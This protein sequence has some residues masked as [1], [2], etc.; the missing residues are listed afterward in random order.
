MFET[1]IL[2]KFLPPNFDHLESLIAPN[3][4][5]STLDN[6]STIQLANKRYKIIQEAKRL[7]LDVFLNVYEIQI[8]EYER[9]YENEFV[10]FQS[11]LLFT[12]TTIN[13]TCVI[14]D[15]CEYITY[16][17][18]KFKQDIYRQI[19]SYRRTLVQ[20]RQHSKLAK[21]TVGVSPE[22]YLD[23]LSNPF[24]QREWNYLALGNIFSINSI[25]VLEF[26]F[27]SM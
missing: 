15:I 25:L 17:T 22:P 20:R 2:C 27:L 11:Q 18:N 1:R 26:F 5:P 7:W 19:L 16:Q 14:N 8:E 24:N 10:Q 9:T 4:G 21:R 3:I 13:R 12:N 6:Q 23:L